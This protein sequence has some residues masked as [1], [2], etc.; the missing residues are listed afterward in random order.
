MP[1][2]VDP[3]V[4]FVVPLELWFI[5]LELVLFKA[6]DP[7]TPVLLTNPNVGLL[8]VTGF[9]SNVNGWL[10][11]ELDCKNWLLILIFPAPWG[12]FVTFRE[13]L[14]FV[15]TGSCTFGLFKARFC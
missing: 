6:E 12:L 3:L 2:L 10:V 13:G 5:G 14:M 11:V 8:F 7:T 9:L 4:P 15:S 1:L